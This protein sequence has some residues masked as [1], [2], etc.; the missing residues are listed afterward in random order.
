MSYFVYPKVSDACP[1]CTCPEA[2]FP[3]RR[4]AP[5]SS[6]VL[7]LMEIEGG[8]RVRGCRSLATTLLPAGKEHLVGACG[9][10]SSGSLSSPPGPPP[11]SST[12]CTPTSFLG[13]PNAQVQAQHS[14]FSLDPLSWH[15]PPWPLSQ[16]LEAPACTAP[17]PSCMSS[18]SLNPWVT[19]P[20]PTCALELWPLLSPSHRCPVVATA[21]PAPPGCLGPHSAWSSLPHRSQ[22]YAHPGVFSPQPISVRC[23]KTPRVLPQRWSCRN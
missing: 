3:L 19:E 4:L 9:P 21:L 6:E 14:P 7:K 22:A 13:L 16:S 1:G 23:L 20:K 8:L 15:L 18:W 12:T 10:S 5:S 11:L 17:S 2:L